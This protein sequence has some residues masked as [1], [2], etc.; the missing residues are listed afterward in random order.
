LREN[1]SGGCRR[2]DENHRSSAKRI[3]VYPDPLRSAG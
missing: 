1:R 2:C 3:R